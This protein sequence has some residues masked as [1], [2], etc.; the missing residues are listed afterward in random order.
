MPDHYSYDGIG[1][2]RRRFTLPALAGHGHLRLRFEAV[3]YVARV[4]LNGIYL[5]EHEGGYTPFEFDVS[6][7]A[8]PGVENTLAVQVDNL[9]A[10]NRLPA[11]LDPGWSFD[12]WNYGGIVRDVSLRI[13]SRAFIAQQQIIAVPHLVAVGEADTA[14]ITATVSIT[15]TSTK[16]LEGVLRTDA[17]DQESGLPALS[18]PPSSPISLPPGKS[19]DVQ[20]AATLV[21]PKLWHFDHPH[22][23]RWI[24][25]VHVVDGQE[26]HSAEVTFGVRSVEL[27]DARLYLNGEPVRL[28]GATRHADSPEHGLAESITVMAADYTDLKTLNA[29]LSRP[30]HYP[31]DDFILDYA[32]RHGILLIPEIPAW[33]LSGAQMA[34]PRMRE[35]VQQQLREMIASHFNH[36]AVWAWSVGNEIASNTAAGHDF[37]QAMTAFVK[38]LDPTRPVGFASNLLNK[39]PWA[40]ATA[41]T[42]FVLMNQYFGTWGGPKEWLDAALDVIHATWPNKAVIIS[43]YGFEPHWERVMGAP[44]PDP[45]QYYAVPSEV[46]SDSETA[47]LQRRQLI[48]EQMALFRSKPF[49]A[50]AIFWTYQDYR[51]PTNYMMGVVDAKRNRRGSWEVLRET[52]APVLLDSVR[53]SPTAEGTH[54]AMVSLRARGPIETDMPA[55]TLRGYRLR[56]LIVS[57][58][59]DTSYS[60]GDLQLPTLAP[61]AVWS[62]DLEWAVPGGEYT[63]TLSIIR[64]T[65]STVIERSYNSQD[66]LLHGTTGR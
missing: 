50:G 17:F 37:I 51:T 7:L 41:Y 23:Y 59:G 28:V 40:D 58:L 5:G 60:G 63:L 6:G 66:E 20:L 35:L 9:R 30:V 32:D 61:G 65:G 44:S 43:E 53:I 36:P 46:P 42:D 21:L 54:R 15:N 1:W 24:A 13:S 57:R 18:P 8:K 26:I 62:G 55:Y 14:T 33:Q 64:P 45:S 47:D 38:V 2:Y 27:R 12:W 10:T 52:Y 48:I 22:L 56:W 11:T 3:F 34:D 4:W 16:H 25:S 49:I 39:T 31:Q 29:V 19:T